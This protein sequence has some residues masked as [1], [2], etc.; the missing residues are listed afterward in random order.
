[1]G[2]DYPFPLGEDIPG[3]LIE[4]RAYEQQ[5]KDKLLYKNALRWLGV[6]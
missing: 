5:V 1:M 4:S 6:E 3:A 2:T